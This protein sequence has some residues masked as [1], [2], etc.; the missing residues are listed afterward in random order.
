MLKTLMVAVGLCV[1]LVA[2]SPVGAARADT[3]VGIGIGL[4]AAN[5]QGPFYWPARSGVNCGEGRRIV[6]SGGFRKV[7][8]LHCHGS[9]YTYSGIRDD[10][11][12]KIT[13]RSSSGRIEDVGRIGRWD[14]YGWDGDYS[15]EDDYSD[16]GYGYSADGFGSGDYGAGFDDDVDF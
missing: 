15:G 1:G 13:L 12:Y 6:A 10:G 7:R 8:P 9:E 14:P 11:Q 16:R 3:L 4:G 5:D 2:A